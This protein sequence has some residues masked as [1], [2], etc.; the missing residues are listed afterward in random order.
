M[1][2]R[3]GLLLGTAFLV[4]AVAGPEVGRLAR[5]GDGFGSAIAQ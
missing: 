5:L 1:T 4:G 3:N 2:L